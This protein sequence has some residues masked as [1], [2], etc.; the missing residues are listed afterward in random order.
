MSE[1]VSSRMIRRRRLEKPELA[2]EEVG[3]RG[4]DGEPGPQRH[5]QAAEDEEE[6][7]RFFDCVAAHEQQSKGQRQHYDPN[8]HRPEYAYERGRH[9]ARR[10]RLLQR[11]WTGL[12]EATARWRLY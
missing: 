11:A 12:E 10:R 7:L 9:C 8:L 6:L 5:R 3:C 4:R 2:G 1:S